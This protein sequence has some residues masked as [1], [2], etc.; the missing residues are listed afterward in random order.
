MG[1]PITYR[2]R[3][4]KWQYG[5]QLTEI[6]G[7]S[8]GYDGQGR[9]TGKG[10][11]SFTYDSNGNLIKQSNGIEFIYDNSGVIGFKYG[12]EN[13]EQYLYRKDAL[14]NIIAVLDRKGAV[15][16]E[17]GYDAWGNCTIIKDTAGVAEV[18]PFRYRGYYY[19]TET[20]LYYLQTR[21][22]D[23]EVGRFISQDDVS[24][25]DPNSINGLNLYAYCGNNP[26]MG[27]DPY[28]T[29]DWGK[30]WGA[31]I[32]AVSA[33]SLSVGIA[34]C[35][36][37]VGAPVGTVLI[38]AGIGGIF[39]STGSAITQGIQNGWNNIDWGQ[40][41]IDGSA[42]LL[43]GALLASPV[44][45]VVTGIAV[46]AVTFV[47]NIGSDLYK[48]NGDWGRV[49]WNTATFQSILSGTVSGIGKYMLQNVNLMN[50]F[51]NS[52]P[53]VKIA[54]EISKNIG[55]AGR[56]SYTNLWLQFIIYR[57]IY[58]YGIKTVVSIL[59]TIIKSIPIK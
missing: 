7:K 57:N 53:S 49:D 40:V 43:T 11:V 41:A 3:R 26:V 46:G 59:N 8:I 15:V 55:L 45:G 29:W 30:F 19:D 9:R 25:L 34:L 6:D 4:A 24:Y 39:G 52:M 18:N 2:G 38:G 17:Y 31:L 22:Y 37:G 23:P 27:Y 35:A 50:N 51:I 58:N 47:Q 36:T 54:A 12:T 42:G 33:V 10:E 13:K 14:G 44:G 48:N 16:V 21:Y 5:K 1:S 56:L 28:G 20:N 32:M